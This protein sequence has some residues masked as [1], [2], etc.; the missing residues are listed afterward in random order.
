MNINSLNAQI[1][2]KIVRLYQETKPS[3]TSSTK[4]PLNINSNKD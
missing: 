3:Y 1:K 2:I 4:N